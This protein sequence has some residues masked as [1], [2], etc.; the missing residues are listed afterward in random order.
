MLARSIRFACVMVVLVMVAIPSAGCY[1]EVHDEAGNPVEGHT[2]SN[3]KGALLEGYDGHEGAEN[4]TVMKYEEDADALLG[5]WYWPNGELDFRDEHRMNPVWTPVD[6]NGAW[7]FTVVKKGDGYATDRGG[8]VS[9][10]G[11]QFTISEKMGSR[12]DTVSFTGDIVGD[13]LVGTV[14]EVVLA[15]TNTGAGV[16]DI[17]WTATR[18]K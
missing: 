18:V 5:E 6:G 13:T 16:F 10:D 15:K 12:G 7:H 8:S 11:K 2:P 17:P 3:T 14:Q 1:G 4:G 9:L